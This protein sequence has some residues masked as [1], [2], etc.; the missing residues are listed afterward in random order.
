MLKYSIFEEGN[1][2]LGDCYCWVKWNEDRRVII[3][4]GNLVILVR[5]YLVKE[6]K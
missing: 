4:C 6:G 2:Y 1:G 5:V 3:G